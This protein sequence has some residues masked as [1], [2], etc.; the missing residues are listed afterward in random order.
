MFGVGKLVFP[1]IP[2]GGLTIYTITI[3]Q[4]F[5]REYRNLSGERKRHFS[6]LKRYTIAL[7]ILGDPFA[8]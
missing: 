7:L 4:K 1:P 2:L 3:L 6:H 5:A 8:A